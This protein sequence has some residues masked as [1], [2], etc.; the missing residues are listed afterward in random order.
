M[1]SVAATRF[2]MNLFRATARH[3][4]MVIII[5][6]DK[7]QRIVSF[8][9]DETRYYLP[10]IRLNVECHVYI[11]CRLAEYQSLVSGLASVCAKLRNIESK[12]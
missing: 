8:F 6:V 11:S 5:N 1:A 7:E 2:S 4:S 3:R 9:R 12:V 10:C